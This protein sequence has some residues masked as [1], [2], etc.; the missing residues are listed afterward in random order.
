ML[1]LELKVSR[2]KV[3]LSLQFLLNFSCIFEFDIVISRKGLLFLKNVM[4]I[5]SHCF[6]A[7]CKALHHMDII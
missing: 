5:H 1:C 4:L 3:T 6:V 7:Q 2:I